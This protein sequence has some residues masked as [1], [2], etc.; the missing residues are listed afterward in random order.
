ME[1]GFPE[2]V[3]TN[4]Q[5]KEPYMSIHKRCIT[6]ATIG[7]LCAAGL[8]GV[9]RAEHTG[10]PLYPNQ[11]LSL[12][13]FGSVSIGQQTIDSLS[14]TRVTKDGRLGAGLG[15]NYFFCRFVGLMG[16]AYT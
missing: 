3:K 6:L 1:S 9:A 4:Q 7:I 10:G 16:E 15:L 8:T 12:D 11:E 13:L 14:G 2:R 5:K